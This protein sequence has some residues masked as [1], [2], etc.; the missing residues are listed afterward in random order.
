VSLLLLSVFADIVIFL[1]KSDETAYYILDCTFSHVHTYLFLTV[2]LSFSETTVAKQKHDLRAGG[3]WI[4]EHGNATQTQPA[5]LTGDKN[6]D[7]THSKYREMS[8]NFWKHPDWTVTS[9]TLGESAT[10][11]CDMHTVQL[12][13]EGST[14]SVMKDWIFLEGQD[15]VVVAI[16]DTK[17]QWI[18]QRQQRYAIPGGPVLTPVQGALIPDKESPLDAARRIVLEQTGLTTTAQEMA[19]LP[20][21]TFSPMLD[22]FGLQDGKVPD[23]FQRDWTFL[24]RYR[25]LG[26]QGG[27]FTYS[28]LLQNAVPGAVKGGTVD[29][30][31]PLNN[32]REQPVLVTM[33][34]Q[35][36]KQT[37][38]NGDFP[39]ITGVATM[40]LALQGVQS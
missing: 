22:D 31:P 39:E 28:Y 21:G 17:G 38:Q 9:R 3:A 26:D 15:Q 13:Q 20:K 25:N 32:L 19:S 4:P 29:F 33:D 34:M 18:V 16:V 1:R 24:G 7:T 36:V 8:E 10:S 14:S 5:E 11:R 2:I 35:H 30:L 12:K 37:L 23:K 40:S 6:A 27:G